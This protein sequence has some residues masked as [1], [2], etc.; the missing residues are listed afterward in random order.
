MTGTRLHRLFLMLAL[1]A[2][3]HAQ[4]SATVVGGTYVVGT[5][6]PTYPSFSTISAALA[7]QPAPTTVQICPGTYNEQIVITQ[8]VSLQGITGGSSDEVTVAPPGVLNSSGFLSN[9]ASVTSLLFVSNVAGAVNVNGITFDG[10]NLPNNNSN[11]LA[12]IV[13][14][15]TPGTL[16]HITTRGLA[17]YGIGVLIEGGGAN[18][19]V[20]VENSSIHDF[21]SFGILVEMWNA[22]TPQVNAT[23]KSNF[24]NANIPGV[25]AGG[26]ELDAGSEGTVSGNW[27]EGQALYGVF[28]NDPNAPDIVTNNTILNP[29][30]TGITTYSDQSSVTGNRVLNANTGILVGSTIATIQSNAI[31]GS[32]LGIDFQ[33]HSDPNVRLNTISD[34]VNGIYRVPSS[35]SVVNAY[36]NVVTPRSGC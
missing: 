15:N 21:Y 20:T 13:Y 12:G 6:K 30:N 5:C 19:S 27:M 14:Q 34:T 10:Q 29:L 26:I 1:V 17:D 24:I 3:V 32:S 9:G 11:Y 36:Y 7:A 25:A 28:I 35:L 8:P 18:P 16:N 31:F 22:T 4:M 2:G 23:I 33:C